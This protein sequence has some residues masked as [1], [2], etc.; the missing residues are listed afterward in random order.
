M[1]VQGTTPTVG[2]GVLVFAWLTIGGALVGLAIGLVVTWLE[3]WVDD[4]PV[5]IA[6]SLIVPYAAYLQ[7]KR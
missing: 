6:L 7:G 1:V 4:G 2:H 3:R 5:E